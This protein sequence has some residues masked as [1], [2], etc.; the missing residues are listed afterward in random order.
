MKHIARTNIRAASSIEKR[1]ISWAGS[2]F[3]VA[4]CL[5]RVLWDLGPSLSLLSS[6]MPRDLSPI[7]HSTRDADVSFPG[8]E[9]RF[10]AE[11]GCWQFSPCSSL[12]FPDTSTH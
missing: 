5:K 8:S 1:E 9:W 4:E 2:I 11:D 10:R 12:D 3:H 7:R 6:T